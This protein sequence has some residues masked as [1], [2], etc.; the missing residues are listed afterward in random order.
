MK[1][2]SLFFVLI[3]GV[4]LFF[5]GNDMG[6]NYYHS[7]KT[8][9]SGKLN[10][11]SSGLDEMVN[12]PKL[13]IDKDS[14]VVGGI[15]VFAFALAV[16][17][18]VFCKKNYMPGKEHGSAE[19]GTASDIAK[20]KDSKYENNMLFTNTESMSLNTRKTRRNNNVLVI[21]GSGSGKTRFFIKPNLL[22][23]HSSY[24]I[25]DPKGTVLT[26]VGKVFEDAG[27]VIKTFNT[28]DFTKSMHYNPF[29]FI[30]TEADIKVFVDILITST[31]EKGEKSA[32]QF[33]ENSERL[34]YM[35]LIGYIWYELPKKEQN[36]SSLLR[37]INSMEVRENDETFMNA[38]DY[39]FEELEI[40]TVEFNKRHNFT[41]K[42]GDKI[43]EPKPEHFAVSQYK[44]YKLA[45][46]DIL[47]K[48][49]IQQ[50]NVF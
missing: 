25:T 32:D 26:E 20:Y 38:I 35:A 44:K 8:D 7:E 40:G 15:F 22:Q 46:G 37:M 27:Y 4:L 19:W 18:K 23:L 48:G 47:Y 5:V 3:C 33:W 14:A 39:A 13:Q 6:Y 36:F 16:I 30:K 50:V 29:T 31:K 17:Y 10:D 9:I 42:D 41:R 43:K 12:A 24:V 49:I 34:L 11:V 45:A 1:I 2:S 28:V 21:G